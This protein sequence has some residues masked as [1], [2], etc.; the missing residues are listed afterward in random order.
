M[1]IYDGGAPKTQKYEDLQK[2]I[3]YSSSNFK[4]IPTSSLTLILLLL[5]LP[6][7]SNSTHL[8]VVP[9]DLSSKLFAVSIQS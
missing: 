7:K 4:S 8:P 3:M 9:A 2:H 1:L 6:R 5:T